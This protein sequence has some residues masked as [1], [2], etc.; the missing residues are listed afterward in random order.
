[1]FSG[2]LGKEN[3]GISNDN[4]GEKPTHQKT[5]VSSAMLISR[6]VVGS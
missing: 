1:M 2:T 5:Q 4:V 3:V 6:G